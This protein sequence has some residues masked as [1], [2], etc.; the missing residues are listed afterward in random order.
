MRYCPA[1]RLPAS[2]PGGRAAAS[3]APAGRR[4]TRRRRRTRVLTELGARV[5][6]RHG[7]GHCSSCRFPRQGSPPPALPPS[8]PPRGNR[9]IA[10]PCPLSGRSRA[11]WRRGQ[12][13]GFALCGE[14]PPPPSLVLS[15]LRNAGTSWPKE[16]SRNQF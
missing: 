1:G 9:V 7:A 11:P 4:R 14:A 3:P 13:P 6:R 15:T 8:R 12:D 10:P 16:R 2:G 5:V